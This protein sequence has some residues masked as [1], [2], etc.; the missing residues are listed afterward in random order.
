MEF[1]MFKKKWLF[2]IS[3]F[4]YIAGRQ[5]QIVIKQISFNCCETIPNSSCIRNISLHLKL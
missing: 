5:M 1:E 4:N 2:S 3:Q